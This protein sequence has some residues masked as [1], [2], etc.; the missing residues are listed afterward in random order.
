MDGGSSF[1]ELCAYKIVVCSKL[2]GLVRY[3]SC[4]HNQ[5]IWGG[6]GK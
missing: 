5:E 4:D 1:A 3:K 2:G 6:G